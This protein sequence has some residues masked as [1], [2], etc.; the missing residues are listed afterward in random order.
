MGITE[1]LMDFGLTPIEIRV[2]L[3]LLK[4][5]VSKAG[6]I[7]K[8]AQ[9]NRT[10]TY[11]ALKRLIAKGLVSY[12]VEANRKVFRPENPKKFKEILKEREEDIDDILPK[13]NMLYGA[14]SAKKGVN[15]S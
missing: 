2:Y 1:T 9:L 8:E 3:A 12:V 11:D 13:L 4:L 5:G 14:V 6:K 15:L 7:A 10:T